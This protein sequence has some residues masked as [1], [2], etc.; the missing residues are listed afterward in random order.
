[1][2]SVYSTSTFA[3][4]EVQQLGVCD[5]RLLGNAVTLVISNI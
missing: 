5:A 3:S 1:M 4:N 2:R